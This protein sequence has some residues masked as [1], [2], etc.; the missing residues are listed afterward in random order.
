MVNMFVIPTLLFNKSRQQE[1]QYNYYEKQVIPNVE[2]ISADVPVIF[3][4]TFEES[5]SYDFEKGSIL[6]FPKEYYGIRIDVT[7]D[8]E[9]MLYKHDDELKQIALDTEHFHIETEKLYN[10]IRQER[11]GLPKFNIDSYI[12]RSAINRQ[13][14]VTYSERYV[15]RY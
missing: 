3:R 2:F 9:L 11:G 4:F 7:I 1:K 10:K 8:D 12:D 13:E 14:H 6:R 5:E 15:G